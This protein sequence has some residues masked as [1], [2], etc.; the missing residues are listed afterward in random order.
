MDPRGRDCSSFL[1]TM[2]ES[3][4]S[5]VCLLSTGSLADFPYNTR[6][7]FINQ[8]PTAIKTQSS[9]RKIYVRLRAIAIS[10]L[11]DR[12]ML[13]DA[14]SNYLKVSISE[15]EDQRVDRG[16]DRC[17]GG[18][19]Y[20]PKTELVQN[21]NYAYHVFS[22]TPYLRLRFSEITR[23]EVRIV[24]LAGELVEGI[25]SGPPT[26]V[27][28][29]VSDS[30]NSNNF[31]ITCNSR[32][33][34]LFVNNTLSNFTS[35][36]HSEMDLSNYQVALVNVMYPPTFTERTVATMTIDSTRFTYI[37]DEFTHTDEFIAHVQQ[38]LRNSRFGNL[39]SFKMYNYG[40]KK[41]RLGLGRER[42]AINRNFK[43][44]MV[45]SFSNT[46]TIAC[47]QQHDFRGATVLIPGHTIV[48]RGQPN[49]DLVKPNPVA[50]LH[51]DIV[52]SGVVGNKMA[53]LLACV[54][55][56]TDRTSGRRRLYEAP[57]LMYYDVVSRPFN[58]ISFTFT[59][60]GG[61]NRA[62]AT[63]ENEMYD[64]LTVTLSF[65]LK[66]KKGIKSIQGE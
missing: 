38:D 29:D 52:Q 4:P 64:N 37:M 26:L 20:P 6:T 55:V 45:V 42:G 61:G 9:D 51:C 19:E 33:P 60:P 28:L 36:L 48:F 63:D 59:N 62:F 41:G 58:S 2:S 1:T 11:Q 54:P 25:Y 49:I 8:L 57:Q 10:C 18:F 12:V 32:Q 47:G 46:F 23:L 43:K 7:H 16:F 53:N 3:L 14:N 21:T 13:A 5:S 31:T 17:A 30:M 65:R 27:L 56:M 34:E 44:K 40:W 24:N 22:R 15:L 66:P 50:T 39:L 35:P